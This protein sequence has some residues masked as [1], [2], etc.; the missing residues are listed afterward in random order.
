MRFFVRPFI[1][2]SAILNAVPQFS[3]FAP[4]PGVLPTT[5]PKA[6]T[7]AKHLIPNSRGCMPHLEFTDGFLLILTL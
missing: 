4:S 1:F 3:I 6:H 7:T 5:K 2:C